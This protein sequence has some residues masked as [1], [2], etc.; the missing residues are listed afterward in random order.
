[1]SSDSEICVYLLRLSLIFEEVVNYNDLAPP[2]TSTSPDSA[3]TAA[4][5]QNDKFRGDANDPA[6][7]LKRDCV[8]V[9]AAFR[10][11]G[12]EGPPF[13]VACTHLYW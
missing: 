13:V 2:P 7:R 5:A 11:K 6:F 8:G 12:V 3:S 4:A 1:M 9:L 10:R